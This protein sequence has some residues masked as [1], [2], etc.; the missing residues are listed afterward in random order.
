MRFV[1]LRRT[2]LLVAAMASGAVA[3]PAEARR[4]DEQIVFASNRAGTFDLY[5]VNADG[6]D[7][8]PIF[9]EPLG[10]ALDEYEPDV[11]P[12]GRQ[13]VFVRAVGLNCCGPAAHVYI[14]NI[15]GTG[16]R[17][18][19]SAGPGVD[20][21]RPQW[22]PDGRRI[23]FSRGSGG[24]SP[25]N[26]FTIRPDGGDLQQLTHE[27]GSSNNFPTWSPDGSMLAFNTNRRGGLEIWV[28]D[29]GGG[30]QRPITSEPAGTSPQWSPTGD[31]VVFRSSRHGADE[32]YTVRSDGTGLTR[33][34][35]DSDAAIAPTWSPDGRRIA[36]V[37]LR[38]VPC[39]SPQCP[40]Q[41]WIMDADGSYARRITEPP[42]TAA[43]PDYFPRRST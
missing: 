11:S 26:V 30:R 20:D 29:R 4:Q 34:T 9:D 10:N 31:R 37:S 24:G 35:T 2:T 43:F 3:I 36:F 42:F 12:D 27:T 5:V 23:A 39:T 15:D 1:R 17:E 14:A 6:T 32:L 13:V 8:R 19:T 33:L 21:Y 7:L 18:L 38:G 22:S 25:S 41:L 28:M 40:T 16:V